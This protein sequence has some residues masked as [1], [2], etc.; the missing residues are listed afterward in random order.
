MLRGSNTPR[1][2]SRRALTNFS[3]GH[4]AAFRSHRRIAYAGGVFMLRYKR[5]DETRVVIID[6]MSVAHARMMAAFLNPGTFVEGRKID[7]ASAA[8]LPRWAVGLVLTQ[9]ELASLAAAKKKPP[10]LSVRRRRPEA[11]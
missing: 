2:R 11:G 5:G 3:R 7:R 4:L 6:G 1:V 9:R 10:A 8:R